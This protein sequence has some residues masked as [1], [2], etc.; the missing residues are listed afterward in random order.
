[1]GQRVAAPSPARIGR[2]FDGTRGMDDSSE[3][4]RDPSI[5][6][7]VVELARP[8][9]AGREE[10]ADG[11]P[12]AVIALRVMEAL[13]GADGELGVTELARELGM[14]KARVHRH[15]TALRDHG[16][17]AQNPR[18][19]RYGIG[20]RLFLLGQQLVR[21]FNVVSLAKPVMEELRDR[22]EQTIVIST[23]TEDEV[24]VLDFV[25]GRS[26]LEMVLRPGT[27]FTFNSVAQG[28][29]ALAFGPPALLE[30]LTAAPLRPSTPHTVID[31]DRLRLEVEMVRRRGW[32]DAP[33]EVFA[34]VNAIAAPLFQA[35]GTLYG[36]LAVV[37]SIHYLP[38]PP[39]EE[40]VQALL[41]A[42]G[43]VSAIM[44]YTGQR[45]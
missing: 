18:T 20:W 12:T 38:K 13:S 14:P 29:I 9:G 8:A 15:L 21:R 34:G 22:V 28:K 44:G 32:A 45:P 25:P 1:M 11:L 17:V 6:P 16:Y 35:D 2:M 39:R 26:A 42:A 33:E 43:K 5:L 24:V 31:P 30:R 40:T 4:T 41:A 27:R 19:N 7:P 3:R 37:G 23:F 36:G 10:L